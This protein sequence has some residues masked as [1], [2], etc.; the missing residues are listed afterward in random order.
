MKILVTGAFNCSK[1]QLKQIES[2]GHEVVFM[3]NEKDDIPCDYDCVEGVV[4][5]GLFLFHDL[6]K[7]TSLRYVQ[8]T[9]AGYDR[10]DVEYLKSKGVKLFNARGV[11]SIPMAEFCLAGVLSLYK[12]MPTFYENKKGKLWEKIRTNR[13]LFGKKVLIIGAGSVGSECAKRFKAFGCSVTGIDIYPVKNDCFD[14]VLPLDSLSSVLAHADVVVLTLPLTKDTENLFSVESFNAMKE[15][16]VLVNIAR[17]KIVDENALL[18][19]LETKLMGA[20]IDVTSVEPLPKE[21]KLWDL[22]NVILSPHNSFVGD[23]NSDRLY[24]LIIQ[25]L[26]SESL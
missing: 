10:V 8:L 3:Q 21:S 11:Y 5:N 15:G 6:E 23:G 26:T 4:C 7:F 25:N 20:V 14:E 13:E 22:D 2:L 16:S 12:N 18:S 19:A 24:S 17:G 1:Q 9:S